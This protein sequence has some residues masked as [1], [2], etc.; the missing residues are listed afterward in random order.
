M[1]SKGLVIAVYAKRRIKQ[2]LTF[3]SHFTYA[4]TVWKQAVH[5]LDPSISTE[6]EESLEHRAKKWWSNE[7]VCEH[8][9][10]PALFVFTIWETRNRAIFKKKIM[11]PELTVNVLLQKAMEH[12]TTPKQKP[13]RVLK[14]SNIE[15]TTPWAFFDAAS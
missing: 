10:F 7:R 13:R 11:S 9:A 8:E 5:K 1:V 4:G 2:I 14:P 15:K 12:Q 6:D 3:F